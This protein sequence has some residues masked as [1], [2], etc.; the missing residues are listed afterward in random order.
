MIRAQP[1]ATKPPAEP[2][3]VDCKHCGK[4]FR[5]WNSV[6]QI[7]C[8][9]PCSQAISRKRGLEKMQKQARMEKRDGRIRLR[10]RRDWVKIAQ[11]AFNAFI[12]ERD[13]F[14]PCVSCG[15]Y[16]ETE[17]QG[18]TFD[19]GHYRTVGAAPQLR[20]DEA[21]AHKQ[22]KECNSGVK[23]QNGRVL[24]AH[25]PERAVTIRQK[26]RTTLIA[27]IGFSEVDRLETD[28][29]VRRQTV[30]ELKGIIVTYRAKLREIRR[31]R[32]A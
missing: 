13:R 3:L 12:R 22:C 9:V 15:F 20:F 5:Q 25:D 32:A 17:V 29:E 8:S 18:G 23:R 21:N 24:V 30:E 2:P 27:R 26:Y 19:C 31:A 7:A 4:P 6:R 10:S 16:T 11:A 28:N 1:A 14:L